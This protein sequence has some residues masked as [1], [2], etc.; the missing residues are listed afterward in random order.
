MLT[1]EQYKQLCEDAE[2]MRVYDGRGTFDLYECQHTMCDSNGTLKIER[3]RLLDGVNI[4]RQGSDS[5][6]DGMP[7]L[8]GNNEPYKDFQADTRRHRA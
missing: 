7:P 6:C 3:M 2:S 5:I 8:P 1:E 4:P